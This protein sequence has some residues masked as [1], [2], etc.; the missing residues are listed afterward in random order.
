MT[1]RIVSVWLPDLPIERLARLRAPQPL[2]PAFALSESGA[3]GLEVAALRAPRGSGLHVGQALADAQAVCPTLAVEGIDRAADAALLDR[4]AHWCLRFTPLVA[5]EGR[6]GLWLDIGGVAHL[7]GGEA[8]LLGGLKTA[9]GK[10]GLTAHA[11]IAPTP[12]A[13]WALARFAPGLIVEAPADL[14]AALAPVPVAG[15]RLDPAAVDLL[16]RF[17]LRR[18][19]DLAAIPRAALET[20]F[21]RSRLVLRYDQALGRVDE[22][23]QPI[24]PP[25]AY[26]AVRCFAEPLRDAAQMLVWIEVLAGELSRQLA[27][28]GLGVRHLRVVAVRVDGE[29]GGFD[30]RF[31]AP[32]RTP[33][34]ILRLA[35]DR[36]EAVDP[37]FGVDALRLEAR[38][39]DALAPEQ[40]AILRR[41]P[42]PRGRLAFADLVA[43]RLGAAAV[44]GLRPAASH[45]P[46]RASRRVAPETAVPPSSSPTALRPLLLL[47]PP[48]PVA[49]VMAEVPDGPPASFVWRKMRHRVARAAGPERIAPEWWRFR[50]RGR[51]RDYFVVECD[52][53]RRF[54]MFRYGLFEE[55]EPPVWHM[56]GLLP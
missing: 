12:G 18:I 24:E 34:H 19:G 10:T 52:D 37:G 16:A 39:V 47:D 48:E 42:P 14:A 5:T 28:A 43:N 36:I 1:R 26:R 21:R 33:A 13:A 22:G 44:F 17:G 6:D 53:G 51:A 31:A 25:P 4:L 7:H 50:S 11:A 41:T 32:V 49:A 45:I 46:E 56:H 20:R 3:H 55:A 38:L 35:R 2:P 40:E 9:L 8:A 54:W 23:I 29:C 30:L 27:G 15:L